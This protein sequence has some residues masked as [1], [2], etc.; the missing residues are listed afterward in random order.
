MA[1]SQPDDPLPLVTPRDSSS[2]K[3]SILTK[4][5]STLKRTPSKVPSEA[6]TP[7]TTRTRLGRSR[8]VSASSNTFEGAL[9]GD[10]SSKGA[11]DAVRV[12]ATAGAVLDSQ[13]QQQQ[14]LEKGFVEAVAGA[15]E[16][17]HSTTA[18]H[19]LHAAFEQ[20]AAAD[21]G[22]GDQEL[23]PQT[24]PLVIQV[25]CE[26]DTLDTTLPDPI[27]AT[28]PLPDDD[29]TN[30]LSTALKQAAE[31]ERV[32]RASL[33]TSSLP[34]LTPV[35]IRI[36]VGEGEQFA[37]EQ[38]FGDVDADVVDL[39]KRIA[40]LEDKDRELRYGCGSGAKL[41]LHTVSSCQFVLT[42]T[43]HSQTIARLTS[44]RD[45][46]VHAHDTIQRAREDMA[47]NQGQ[48]KATIAKLEG[49]VASSDKR[50]RQLTNEIEQLTVRC[51]QLT[52]QLTTTSTTD[53]PD[54]CKAANHV[55]QEAVDRE[56]R[57][58]REAQAR[59]YALERVLNWEA[60]ER[61]NLEEF[62]A[63]EVSLLWEQETALRT[64]LED[65]AGARGEHVMQLSD[66]RSK[67]VEMSMALA[68]RDKDTGALRVQAEQQA[69]ALQQAA[70]NVRAA[71][72]E[73]DL[74]GQSNEQ[75]FRYIN[76]VRGQLNQHNNG[77]QA[78]A[79][80][81]QELETWC[82][83]ESQARASGKGKGTAL[84]SGAGGVKEGRHGFGSF[85]SKTPKS[86]LR[87][88]GH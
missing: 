79:K 21:D 1:T 12:D 64:Q 18:V 14:L 9:A 45:Q 60:R 25:P 67:L 85:F 49:I 48:L 37:Q 82:A 61:A 7:H 23:L 53:T 87:R 11:D 28:T 52:S 24:T 71:E 32:I 58:A 2:K 81:A 51:E 43:T 33:D 55:L 4:I 74:V 80:L 75:Y 68:S 13:A 16:A 70:A 17:Q 39:R 41:L 27:P 76:Y 63:T 77:D 15:E 20:A 66:E 29:V 44:E 10:T 62:C 59:V 38:G 73:V 50:T 88:G 40:V 57:R 54:R 84:P 69:Q 30:E 86:L 31:M 19:S 3:R 6:T 47:R 8:T 46:A 34:P 78:L 83:A 65:L 72:A 5:K 56:A 36:K 22:D 42:T 26:H 35:V